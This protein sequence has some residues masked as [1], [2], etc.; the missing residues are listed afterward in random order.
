ME[1]WGNMNNFFFM[2]KDL[3]IQLT[4]IGDV[5][6]QDDVVLTILIALLESY[7]TFVQGIA[8]QYDLPN[9]DKLVGNLS[10]ESTTKNSRIPSV[11]TMKPYYSSFSNYTL[12]MERS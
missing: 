10:N 8:T 4:N 7:K 3:N 2:V 12:I 1:K 6:N 9:F 11:L 5:I